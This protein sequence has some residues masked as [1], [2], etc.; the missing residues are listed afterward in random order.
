MSS[1][2]KEEMG[3]MD[4]QVPREAVLFATEARI[5]HMR[6]VAGLIKTYC[7]AGPA[8]FLVIQLG[9]ERSTEWKT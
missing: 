8:H 6:M 5:H 4:F 2:M 7:L 1:L 3:G 9:P